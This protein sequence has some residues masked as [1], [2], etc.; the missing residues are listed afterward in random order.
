[1]KLLIRVLTLFMLLIPAVQDIRS[2]E[3][4]VLPPFLFFVC[5]MS[6]KGILLAVNQRQVWEQVWENGIWYGTG[7]ILAGLLPGAIFYILHRL[8]GGS[9][10]G[11]DAYLI[12]LLGMICGL[13]ETA[14][15]CALAL[16]LAALAGLLLMAVRKNGSD[17]EIP[18]VPFL[19]AA[20]LLSLAV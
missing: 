6:A 10:G 13:Y 5:A 9:V 1:M 3:F 14:V 2:K 19:L 7:R 8:T 20:C 12:L 11:G 15:I 17:F 16:A 4:S 18:F